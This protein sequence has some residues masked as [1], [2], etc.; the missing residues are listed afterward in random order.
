M[1][2]GIS[3]R[4]ALVAGGS[5]GLGGAAARALAGEGA[6]LFVSARGA[7][8]LEAAA[9]AIRADTGAEVTAIVADHGTEA[10]RARLFE[11]CPA[12]DILVISFSPPPLTGDYRGVTP[13]QWRAVFEQMVI[14][15]TELMRHYSEGMAAR[16]FG[17][18]VNL[19]TVAAKFPLAARMLSGASRAAVAN[20]AAGLA[21]L[22][23]RSN[24]TINAILPGIFETPGLAQTFVDAAAANGTAEAEEREKFLRRLNIPARRYG[25]PDE[26]GK[27]CAMLCSAHAG[28]VTGQSLTVDGGL[29]GGLF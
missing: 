18:I 5:A 8:R 24:V 4:T 17:R 10:G 28:Y 2:L 9:E 16:G 11:A 12:P 26:A 29:G 6:R 14:G 7:E 1:D 19:S 20:Y 13:E 15:S 22:L 27:L 3:G 25:Q 23:A 21:R